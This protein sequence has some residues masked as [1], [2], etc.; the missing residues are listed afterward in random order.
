[1]AMVGS[2]IAE[3]SSN[4]HNLHRDPRPHSR[5]K[6]IAG[7]NGLRK[8]SCLRN[9]LGLGVHIENFALGQG[10][11]DCCLDGICMELRSLWNNCKKLCLSKVQSCLMGVDTP[12]VVSAKP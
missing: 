6:K 1:M 2:D 5:F 10:G 3:A 4:P 8:P 11:S 7:C 12:R 9:T